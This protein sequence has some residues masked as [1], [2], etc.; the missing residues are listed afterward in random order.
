MSRLSKWAEAPLARVIPHF[1]ASAKTHVC[2][3]LRVVNNAV[4]PS[5]EWLAIY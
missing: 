2:V 1:V 5:R 3:L 4:R